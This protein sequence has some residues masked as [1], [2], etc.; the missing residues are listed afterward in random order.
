M[1]SQ[2]TSGLACRARARARAAPASGPLATRTA[3]A[4]QL[5]SPSALRG[6][7]ARAA[8]RDAAP[9]P[10]P[11][12]L[13][14][15]KEE[16]VS[17]VGALKSDLSDWRGRLDANVTSYRAEVRALRRARS[18]G[19]ERKG[20]PRSFARRWRAVKRS[21]RPARRGCGAPPATRAARAP[22]LPST[23]LGRPAARTGLPAAGRA[24]L[25]G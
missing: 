14:G 15:Q 6:A 9:R 12:E 18:A 1:S 10:R 11:Q 8:A 7:H 4:H 19:G 21:A 20:A 13:Q 5:C 22:A 23:R 3:R 24:E 2:P 25:G 16:L 17:K